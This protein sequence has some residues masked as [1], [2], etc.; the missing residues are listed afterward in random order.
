LG[1]LRLLKILRM[2]YRFVMVKCKNRPT[3]IDTNSAWRPRSVL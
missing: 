3:A 2:R 1:V